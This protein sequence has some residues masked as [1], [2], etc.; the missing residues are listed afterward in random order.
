MYV[1]RIGGRNGVRL[2]RTVDIP[3]NPL[4]G[5]VL[6]FGYPGGTGPNLP[7]NNSLH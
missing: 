7:T 1:G 2:A 4:E 3:L 6:K 5:L